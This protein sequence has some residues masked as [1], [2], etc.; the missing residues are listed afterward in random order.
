MH[1]GALTAE[2]HWKKL[3][4]RLDMLEC[5]TGFLTLGLL[6]VERPV[7]GVGR[8]RRG[9]VNLGLTFLT[10][11]FLVGAGAKGVERGWG[12]RGKCQCA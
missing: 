1:R 12:T 5:I 6:G 2:S 4:T 8:A 11:W 10:A 3:D 9:H 7:P